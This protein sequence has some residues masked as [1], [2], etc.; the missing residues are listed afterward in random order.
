MVSIV[1][2]NVECVAEYKMNEMAE[3]ELGLAEKCLDIAWRLNAT[4]PVIPQPGF[5]ID[6]SAEM[7]FATLHS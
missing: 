2:K 4:S 5:K 6:H 3:T 1:T 7:K